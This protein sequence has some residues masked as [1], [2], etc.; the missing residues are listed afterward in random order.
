MR[1]S[2]FLLVLAGNAAA[3]AQ[4]GQ[5]EETVLDRSRT[6]LQ[7]WVETEQVISREKRD[8]QMAR[9]VLEQRIALLRGEIE[10]LEQKVAESEAGLSEAS[11]KRAEMAAESRELEAAVTSLAETIG[12]IEAKTKRLVSLLPAPL[13]DRVAP[14]SRRLPADS[15]STKL[16]LAERFQNVIGVLNEVNK[17][18]YDVHV[19][20]ERRTLADGRSAEVRSLYL[21]LGQ[22]YYV[23]GDGAHAGVGV[24]GEDG[25]QWREADEFAAQ[26]SRAIAML[27]NQDVPDYVSVPVQVQ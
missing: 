8:W 15:S 5:A 21:G 3:L 16:G 4:T 23:T 13:A 2:I 17:F 25:W 10:S 18:N 19:V 11:G 7:K 12:R 9:E 14:L 24:P 1:R 27:E 20:N 26:I 6:T 22:A